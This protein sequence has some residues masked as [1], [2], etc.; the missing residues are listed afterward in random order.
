MPTP[1]E[2]EADLKPGEYYEDCAYHPCLCV[3]VD[4][5][6]VLGISLIDGTH[7]RGCSIFGCGIRKL[8]L[9]EALKWKFSGPEDVEIPQEQK[10]WYKDNDMEKLL[11]N[12][13]SNT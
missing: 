5:D 11:F 9:N 10:W 2:N 4:D 8:S 6:E 7:P 12:G 13:T 1:V 3:W